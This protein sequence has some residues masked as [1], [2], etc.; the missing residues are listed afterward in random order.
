MLYTLQDPSKKREL[1]E[2]CYQTGKF[3]QEEGFEGEAMHF[4]RKAK[5]AITP[6]YEKDPLMSEI[7]FN[8]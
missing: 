4:Y 8:E 3:W 7:S 6:E 5:N 1:A 2:L